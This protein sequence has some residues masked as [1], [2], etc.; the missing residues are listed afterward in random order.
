MRVDY[1]T[2]GGV[3]VWNHKDKVITVTQRTKITDPD[4]HFLNNIRTHYPEYR[5]VERF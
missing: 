2:Y 1:P 5:I 3:L 4:K